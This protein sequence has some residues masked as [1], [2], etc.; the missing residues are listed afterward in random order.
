MWFLDLL[1]VVLD[2]K[3]PLELRDRLVV[4]L[5]SPLAFALQ[6]LSPETVL[7]TVLLTVAVGL[8][9]L[10]QICLPRSRLSRL[11]KVLA[12]ACAVGAVYAGTCLAPTPLD[13]TFYGQLPIE[14]EKD[15]PTLP[16]IN[17]LVTH[18]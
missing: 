15:Y 7:V 12:M 11:C 8:F 9:T 16:R 4:P 3:R 18:K 1:E 2:S 6:G 10:G 17:Q 13:T 5:L 14:S